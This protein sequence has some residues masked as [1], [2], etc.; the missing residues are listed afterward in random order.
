MAVDGP[1]LATRLRVRVV[2]W[3]TLRHR[4][5]VVDTT[6]GGDPIV[7]VGAER[8]VLPRGARHFR[9]FVDCALCGTTF[10]GAHPVMSPDDLHVPG[11]PAICA[12]CSRPGRLQP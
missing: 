8:L 11:R 5:A 1:D 3:R 2:S 9:R 10:M 7:V 12:S 4:V 6:E